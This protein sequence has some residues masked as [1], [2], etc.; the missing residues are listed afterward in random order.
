MADWEQ[1]LTIHVFHNAFITHRI[2]YICV[3][4]LKSLGI[5]LATEQRYPKIG[6]V[7]RVML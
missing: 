3:K 2:S 4:I 1:Q 6:L 7:M 5:H